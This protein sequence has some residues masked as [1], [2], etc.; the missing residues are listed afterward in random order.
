MKKFKFITNPIMRKI[1]LCALVLAVGI[2]IG[3]NIGIPLPV[4]AAAPAPEAVFVDLAANDLTEVAGLVD[5]VVSLAP[6]EYPA[7]MTDGTTAVV[8]VAND[9]V[10][11]EPVMA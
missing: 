6:G 9:G 7:V 4:S 3:Q 10:W 11:A 5:E 1:L 2:T 8:H